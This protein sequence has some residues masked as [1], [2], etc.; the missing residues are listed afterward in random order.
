MI[1]CRG[2]Q[3]KQVE[4][5]LDIGKHP[6]SNH[7][8]KCSPV[9]EFHYPLVIGQCRTCGVVQLTKLMPV[10]ELISPYEWITYNEPEG[11]LGA[12][13]RLTWLSEINKGG[14]Y[15]RN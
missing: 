13:D 12:L 15:R 10:G 4:D 3:S 5:L 9:E 6:I 14:V 8:L 11:H 2:C 7:F 1:L